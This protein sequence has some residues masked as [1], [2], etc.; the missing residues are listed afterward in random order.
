[1]ATTDAA[2]RADARKTQVATASRMPA[3]LAIVVTAGFFGVL[4][5]LIRYGKPADGGDALLLLG[6]LGTAWTS[7]VAYYFGSTSA[8]QRKTELMAQQVQQGQGR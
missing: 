6:S 4:G 1:M 7:V 3:L 5:L 8:S 2:D